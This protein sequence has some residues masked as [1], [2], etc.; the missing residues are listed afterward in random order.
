MVLEFPEFVTCRKCG[1]ACRVSRTD[2]YEMPAGVAGVAW[3]RCRR[4]RREFVHFCGEERPVALL[5]E[6]WLALH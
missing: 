4:C 3:A 5:I 1:R 6:R 2:T